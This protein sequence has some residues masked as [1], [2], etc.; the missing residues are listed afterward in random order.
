VDGSVLNVTINLRIEK[1]QI[2]TW[3]QIENIGKV[4]KS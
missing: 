4:L 3:E 2:S 1:I